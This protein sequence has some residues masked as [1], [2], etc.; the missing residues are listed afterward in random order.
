MKTGILATGI[1]PDALINQYG[2]YADMFIQLLEPCHPELTYRVYD[3]QS[4][5]FPE[6]ANDCDGWI[7]TGSKFSVYEPLDWITRL[8]AL[9]RDI[10][11]T[12]R[13]LVGICFGHQII[14]E[15]LGGK[16]EKY[17]GGWGLG[18][19]TYELTD[20]F[21]QHV[22]APQARLAINA[23][24]QDQVVRLPPAANVIAHSDFCA[25][26]GLSYF[27]GR[28]VSL[29]AHPEFS[30]EFEHDLLVERGGKG[31]PLEAARAGL[32]HLQT[33]DIGLDAPVIAQWMMS[34]L[35]RGSG[36]SEH[37]S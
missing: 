15:A 35:T 5:E 22:N 30:L 1:T 4:G 12:D 18:V 19:H 24:H 27:D 33:P 34:V 14:A 11:I 37:H 25:Y 17:D 6:S 21:Q 26:A 16:V 10:A 13:P 8:K 32:K 9:I 2:S 3:V 36:H 23:V 31:I 29:Q 20:A 7:I 28:I